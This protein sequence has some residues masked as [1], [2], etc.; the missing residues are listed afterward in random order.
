M[1]LVNFR[2]GILLFVALSP[3]V[4]HSFTTV[5]VL[6]RIADARICT[7]TRLRKRESTS[8]PVDAISVGSLDSMLEKARRRQGRHLQY[9]LQAIWDTPVLRIQ[10]P[11]PLLKSSIL[12]T[13]GDTGLSAIA[14]CIGAKGL[15]LGYIMGKISAGPVREILRPNWQVQSILMPLWSVLWAV[16]FDQLL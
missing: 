4:S 9:E 7:S 8:E 5:N 11:Y 1:I 10:K 13:V 14:L 15:A 16:G 2:A 3:L 12:L 6:S